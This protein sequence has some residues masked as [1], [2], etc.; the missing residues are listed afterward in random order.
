MD[1]AVVFQEACVARQICLKEAGVSMSTYKYWL[2]KYGVAGAGKAVSAKRAAQPAGKKTSPLNILQEMTENRKKRQE[3]EQ[4][5]KQ[6]RQLDA[7]YEEL[8]KRL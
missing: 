2:K 7:R 8:R 6:I 5:E 3:L 1:I 4:A